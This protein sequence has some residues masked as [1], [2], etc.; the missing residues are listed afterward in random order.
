[1]HGN[2]TDLQE[3]T[4]NVH[5]QQ[6]AYLQYAYKYAYLLKKACTRECEASDLECFRWSK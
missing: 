1:M 6:Y 4:L 2:K 3:L 5:E